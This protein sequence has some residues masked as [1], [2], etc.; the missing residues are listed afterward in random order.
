MTEKGAEKGKGV[1]PATEHNRRVSEAQKTLVRV[2]VELQDLGAHE[3]AIE[4]LDVINGWVE[5]MYQREM[6]K[7]QLEERESELAGILKETGELTKKQWDEL[8]AI[9]KVL[10]GGAEQ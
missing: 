2:S 6:S 9:A 8:A 5:S 7:E 4:V 10:H 3:L 1:L